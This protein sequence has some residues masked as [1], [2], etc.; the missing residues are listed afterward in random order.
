[1]QG[2]GEQQTPPICH[3]WRSPVMA[4]ALTAYD[5][6]LRGAVGKLRYQGDRC[7]GWA[8]PNLPLP[9]SSVGTTDGWGERDRSTGLRSSGSIGHTMNGRVSRTGASFVCKSTR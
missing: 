2:G 7:G 5:L 3:T 1:M 8:A 6:L 9:G 4:F